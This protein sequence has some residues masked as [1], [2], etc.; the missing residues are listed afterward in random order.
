MLRLRCA[1]ASDRWDEV[2]AAEQREEAENV[3]DF[4]A[5]A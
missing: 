5:A 2:V 1:W 4:V 3:N